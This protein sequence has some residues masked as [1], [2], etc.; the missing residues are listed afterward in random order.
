LI[1]PG[2]E[3]MVFYLPMEAVKAVSGALKTFFD[4][5]T[6]PISVE[7]S[8]A[9]G[10]LKAKVSGTLYIRTI[11]IKDVLDRIPGYA[12]YDWG[13]TEQLK[14]K[15]KIDAKWPIG[16]R[17]GGTYEYDTRT[18]TYEPTYVSNT[19]GFYGNSTLYRSVIDLYENTMGYFTHNEHID[20]GSVVAQ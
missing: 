6:P 3:G 1:T 19:P 20:I 8:T 12:Y 5:Y 18:Y 11:L 2:K 4:I 17:P 15:L 9:G 16:K 7:Y 14:A 13:T 10:Y